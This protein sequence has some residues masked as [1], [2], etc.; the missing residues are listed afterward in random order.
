MEVERWQFRFANGKG[1]ESRFPK[2]RVATQTFA[3]YL[4][5]A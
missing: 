2:K 3:N 5:R 1:F 4:L